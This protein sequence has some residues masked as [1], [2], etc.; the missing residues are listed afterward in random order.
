MSA[1]IL[2][3]GF[4]I[5]SIMKITATSLAI[6]ILI[7]LFSSC[8]TS[9]YITDQ[10]SIKRQK[11]MRKYRTGRNFLEAGIM[12]AAAVGQAL[13]DVNVYPEPASQSFRKFVLVNKSQDTLF[14][15]MVTDWLWRDSTYC[16]IREIVMPPL[17][18]AKVIVPMGVSYNVFFRNDFNAPDDEKVEIN[19]AE[20][21]RVRLNPG[22]EKP[23]EISNN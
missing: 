4:Q 17:Q 13:T 5:A 18:S 1:F 16:D 15:N 19:T 21:G 10:E 2:S 9:V 20:T 7:F 23:K 14:I 22:K 8:A 3:I 12:F 11:E 6:C